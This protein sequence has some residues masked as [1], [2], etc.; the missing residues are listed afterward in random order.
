MLYGV[1]STLEK[2]MEMEST[3]A[4]SELAKSEEA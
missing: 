4:L 2:Q 1:L 3:G